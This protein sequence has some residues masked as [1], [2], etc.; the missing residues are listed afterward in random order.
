[1]IKNTDNEYKVTRI[2]ILW[3][4]WFKQYFIEIFYIHTIYTLSMVTGSVGND[5]MLK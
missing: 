4:V 5:V 2:G 1:M 3:N